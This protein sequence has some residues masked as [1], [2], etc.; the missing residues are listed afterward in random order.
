M[1][2]RAVNAAGAGV[3]D[4]VVVSFRT[5]SY[6]K[7]SFLLYLFPVLAMIAGAVVG[8]E[9]APMFGLDPGTSSVIFG[10]AFFFLSIPVVRSTSNRMAGKAEYQPKVSKVL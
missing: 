9:T 6:L 2:V 10:F 3:G 1:E 8:Q 4:R 7:A 5:A